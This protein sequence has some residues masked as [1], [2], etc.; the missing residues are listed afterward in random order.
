MK[1]EIKIIL[2][3]KAVFSLGITVVFAL[4][5]GFLGISRLSLWYGSFCVFYLLLAA[6]R[7]TVLLTEHKLQTKAE[8]EKIRRKT[9]IAGS[10]I[11]VILSL[12]LALPVSLA[13]IM[14]RPVD[15][16]IT[17]AIA[18][19]A[20]TTYKVTSVCVRLKKQRRAEKEP[21]S[22]LLGGI[23]L[24][25]ALVSVLMLQNT[26][27]TAMGENEKM[28]TLS[29]VT[30]GGIYGL[31]LIISIGTAVRGTKSLSEKISP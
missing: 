13:V 4:Y 25:D 8:K 16:G 23:N 19:A 29:S 5:N 6:V 26:L 11:M 10:V 9:Y 2:K 7:G 22:L 18:M 14:K 24:T 30:S 15:I 27:I 17:P 21:L 28:L 3:H 12:S 1:N 20:Y 31:I